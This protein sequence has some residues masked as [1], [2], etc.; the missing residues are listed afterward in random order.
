LRDYLDNINK[1]RKKRTRVYADEE[2]VPEE[3][4]APKTAPD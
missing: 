4:A 3:E 1:S 2:F